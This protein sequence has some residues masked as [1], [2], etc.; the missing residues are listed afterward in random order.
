MVGLSIQISA[1]YLE[2]ASGRLHDSILAKFIAACFA[3]LPSR[4][5]ISSS[6][7]L[8]ERSNRDFVRR[9]DTVKEYYIGDAYTEAW[10]NA[11]YRALRE[12]RPAGATSLRSLQRHKPDFV[13]P[14]PPSTQS[15]VVSLYF[16]GCPILKVRSLLYFFIFTTKLDYY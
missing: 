6:F 8:D 13:L 12:I 1:S 2:R 15:I 9:L 16:W 14:V 7:T 10:K 11:C 5:A 4:N 3:G